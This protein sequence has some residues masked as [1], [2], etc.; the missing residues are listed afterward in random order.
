MFIAVFLPIIIII[1]IIIVLDFFLLLSLRPEI[2]C[3]NQSITVF[4][5]E[6]RWPI[7]D[8]DFWHLN[9]KGEEDGGGNIVENFHLN[10]P[11]SL[12]R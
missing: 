12:R 6:N 3:I 5:R 4:R 8:F 10:N 1:I 2:G 7:S 9:R 11:S